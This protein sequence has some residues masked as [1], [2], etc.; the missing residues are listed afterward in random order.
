[1]TKEHAM[2]SSAAELD[3]ERIKSFVEH[4]FGMLS[5]AV[6]SAMIHLGDRLGLYRALQG[7][8]P[9]TSEELARKTGLHERWVREW[10]QGQATAGLLDYKGDGRFA[11]SPEAA[12]V[13]A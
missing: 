8:G 2:Q 10:L 11:L 13:L 5:G 3:P 6:V 7:A 4:V 1:M 12:L 9:I